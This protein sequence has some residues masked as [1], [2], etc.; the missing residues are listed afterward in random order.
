MQKNCDYGVTITGP[1]FDKILNLF[2]ISTYAATL[3]ILSLVIIGNI[4]W[5]HDS[6]FTLQKMTHSTLW[7]AAEE[8]NTTF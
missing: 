8:I 6:V 1:P 2:S 5:P 4:H 7:Q 3:H